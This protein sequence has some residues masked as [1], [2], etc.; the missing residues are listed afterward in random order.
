MPKI[1][2]SREMFILAEIFSFDSST[3]FLV[4]FY[5][6]VRNIQTYPSF[7]PTCIYRF[8]KFS[9]PFDPP[10]RFY[11]PFAPKYH[12]IYPLHVRQRDSIHKPT[13]DHVR[14]VASGTDDFARRCLN[15]LSM[16][17]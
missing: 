16:V 6:S 8:H 12:G 5:P 14:R 11:E 9:L 1:A 10:V 2:L 15:R 3:Q 4:T 17:T 13:S 7:A